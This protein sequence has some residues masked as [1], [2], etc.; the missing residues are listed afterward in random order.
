MSDRGK[1]ISVNISK[2]KGESKSPVS[3]ITIDSLGVVNDAH[4]GLWH[5]QVSILAKEEI[6]SFAEAAGKQIAAGEFAE[7]ITASGIDLNKVSVLD[8]LRIGNVRLQITQIGKDCHGQGCDIY[9][10]IGKC[11]MPSKGI[12]CRVIEGG[13]VAS[14]NT[15][16]LV[17][18]YLNVLIITLSD[19]AK[20]G[21]YS[22]M[23]GPRAKQVIEEFFAKKTWRLKIEN[24]LI[25]DEAD[26]L[27]KI[28]R[29]AVS[30]GVDIIFTLG[31]TGVGPRDITPET[32]AS[33]GV[34]I[35]PGI[36]ENIRVKFGRTKPST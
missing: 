18:K 13:T 26:E 24:L 10:R 29:K 22:D 33:L 11:V 27:L 14:D 2:L 6:D 3:E 15:I 16:E 4:A 1:V 34:K 20:A 7:N 21:E 32:I 17:P 30:H 23:S 8:E 19:R 36:M 25:A 12:F 35:I 5:R 9:Q 28:L 31:G